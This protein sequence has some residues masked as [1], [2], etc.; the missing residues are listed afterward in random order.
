MTKAV[1]AMKETNNQS[2]F[3]AELRLQLSK[4]QIW[5]NVDLP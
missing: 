4:F 5:K 2:V 3:Q 1:Q